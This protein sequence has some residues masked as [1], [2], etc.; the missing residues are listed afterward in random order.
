MH[1]IRFSAG[2]EPQTPLGELIDPLLELG[3][4]AY[5]GREGT[6]GKEREKVKGGKRREG[7]VGKGR[8]FPPKGNPV[9]GPDRALTFDY[10]SNYIFDP[11]SS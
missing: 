10:K 2:T 8:E 11:P 3:V 6:G 7:M 9:Y 4:L 5:K 1:Q